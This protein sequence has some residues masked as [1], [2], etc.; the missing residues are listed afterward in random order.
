MLSQGRSVSDNARLLYAGAAIALFCVE[1]AIALFVN[2]AF[3]RPYVGDVLAILL[4]Y[5]A[6][7]AATPLSLRA[8]LATTLAIAVLIEVAQAAKL[9]SALGLGENRL[10]RIVFGGS[11]DWLDLLAYAAGGIVIVGIELARPGKGA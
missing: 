5:T 11:F 2:D 3:V 8:A 7:R 6:L 1:V 10:A 9:L 4:V